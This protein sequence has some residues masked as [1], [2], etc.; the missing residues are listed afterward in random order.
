[1]STPRKRCPVTSLCGVEAR[2]ES[3]TAE[4]IDMSWQLLDIRPELF[5]LAAVDTHDGVSMTTLRKRR[6]FAASAA[7]FMLNDQAVTGINSPETFCAIPTIF[8]SVQDMLLH[9][10]KADE[11]EREVFAFEDVK[12]DVSRVARKVAKLRA[13]MDSGGVESINAL[14]V[15]KLAGYADEKRWIPALTKTSLGYMRLC[16]DIAMRC[17]VDDEQRCS[18]ALFPLACLCYDAGSG[19]TP[20]ALELELDVSF[21]A[22]FIHPARPPQVTRASHLPCT[23][24]CSHVCKQDTY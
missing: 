20:D 1:M 22:A 3:Q 21:W 2:S 24:R 18:C 12:L 11:L 14:S 23:Q 17:S 19:H 9:P 16:K 4:D 5:S 13:Q 15:R 6:L 10:E 7:T 8:D